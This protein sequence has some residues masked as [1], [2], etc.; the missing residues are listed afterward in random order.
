[1]R[2]DGRLGPDTPPSFLPSFPYWNTGALQCHG[3][4][5][6]AMTG[7]FHAYT[8]APSLGVPPHPSRSPW[9]TELSLQGCTEGSLCLPISHVAGCVYMS[10]LPSRFLH[11]LLPSLGPQ[12]CSH[13]CLYSC[14]AGTHLYQCSRFYMYAL[15]YICS[16]LTYFTLHD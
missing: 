1:M 16:S 10:A 5:C 12:V 9:G 14:P 15:I 6:C 7:T 8:L 11:A 13:T 2:Q 4:L 3:S